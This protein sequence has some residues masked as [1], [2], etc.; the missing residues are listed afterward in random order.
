MMVTGGVEGEVHAARARGR[1]GSTWLH[2]PVWASAALDAL[3]ASSTKL[4]Q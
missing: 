1:D 3:S 2:G 4:Q